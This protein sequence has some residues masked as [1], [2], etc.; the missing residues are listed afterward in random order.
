[1]K[2]QAIY[3]VEQGE[4]LASVD[5]TKYLWMGAGALVLVGGFFYLLSRPRTAEVREHHEHEHE[6]E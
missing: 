5:F 6:Y 3:L 1:M 2:D 4:K